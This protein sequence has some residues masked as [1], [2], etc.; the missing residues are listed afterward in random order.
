MLSEGHQGPTRPLVHGQLQ[1][2]S[3]QGD[4]RLRNPARGALDRQTVSTLF[5]VAR[6]ITRDGA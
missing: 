6:R 2:H 1:D 3:L 4:V 5:R